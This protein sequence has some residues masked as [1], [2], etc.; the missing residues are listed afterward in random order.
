VAEQAALRAETIAAFHSSAAVQGADTGDAEQEEEGGLFTLREKT[1][2][3]VE[4]EEAEYRAYL[5]REVG[6]LEK[7]LDLGEEERVG[8]GMRRQEEDVHLPPGD[9]DSGKK[10]KKKG[11]KVVEEKKETDQEFLIKC[12]RSLHS[13]SHNI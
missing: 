6:P 12:V 2:N 4:R 1:K 8:D 11:G 7:I 10:R 5:E 13:I 9:A 3:E